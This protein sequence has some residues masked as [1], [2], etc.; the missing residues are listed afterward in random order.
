MTTTELAPLR[1]LDAIRGTR[2]T[3]TMTDPRWD[4]PLAA[5]LIGA[6][7]DLAERCAQCRRLLIDHDGPLITGVSVNS[8]PAPLYGDE[9]CADASALLPGDVHNGGWVRS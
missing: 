1:T 6:G 9:A 8:Q 5:A 3:L 7:V 2:P 4:R